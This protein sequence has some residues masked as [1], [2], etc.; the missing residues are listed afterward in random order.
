MGK[1]W[2]AAALVC[3][4]GLVAACG[5]DEPPP[6]TPDVVLLEVESGAAQVDRGD[7][8]GPADITGTVELEEGDQIAIGEGSRAFFVNGGGHVLLLTEGTDM[9]FS[10]F[11]K[12]AGAVMREIVV[13]QR[14]GAILY[15]IPKLTNGVFFQVRVGLTTMMVQG[16]ATELIVVVEGDDNRVKIISGEVDVLLR[17]L[18][19]TVDELHAEAGDVVLS[20]GEEGLEMTAGGPVLPAED[21]L[22]EDLR[23][24]A[25]AVEVAEAGRTT[26]TVL[27]LNL[28][29]ATP[30]I[31]RPDRPGTPVVPGEPLVAATPEIAG[32]GV[33]GPESPDRPDDVEAGE[34]SVGDG[35]AEPQSGAPRAPG[36]EL[37]RAVATPAR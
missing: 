26:P 25:A 6:L 37:P 22:L 11:F 10:R 20:M 19:G 3:L 2:V 27:P 5:S 36:V 4:A 31:P 32:G 23:A 16:S 29:P 13:D 12:I 24:R 9:G 7:E 30:T 34:P 8:S 18:D 28:A 21:E 14:R 1:R 15:S 35:P 17:R 33:S